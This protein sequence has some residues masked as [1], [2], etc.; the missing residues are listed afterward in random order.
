MLDMYMVVERRSVHLY[1]LCKLLLGGSGVAFVQCKPTINAYEST[2][3]LFCK[4]PQDLQNLWVHAKA[5]EACWSTKSLEPVYFR[6]SKR[7]TALSWKSCFPAADFKC[8]TIWGRGW[9]T[10][11]LGPEVR[12][13]LSCSKFWVC[14]LAP[15]LKW[16]WVCYLTS[17]NLG[18]FLCSK[19]FIACQSWQAVV[20]V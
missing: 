11:D 5:K 19:G 17:L 18:I 6:S 15:P 7:W 9:H 16:P 13:H 4:P 20:Q 12:A 3:T 8:R 14:F 1:F 2:G 10:E